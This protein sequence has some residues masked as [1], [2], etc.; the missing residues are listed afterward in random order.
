M[1]WHLAL[2]G[3]YRSVS[4]TNTMLLL[5]IENNKT[6]K[7]LSVSAFSLF[8]SCLIQEKKKKRIFF[9]MRLTATAVHQTKHC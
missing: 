6:H 1:K 3:I 8:G 2:K 7:T 5:L 4:F 9:S